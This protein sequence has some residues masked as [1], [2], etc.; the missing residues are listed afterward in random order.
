MYGRRRAGFLLSH[1]LELGAV[2][3]EELC[4]VL[5][6]VPVQ[7]LQV[8]VVDHASKH[9][10]NVIFVVIRVGQRRVQDYLTLAVQAIVVLAVLLVNRT[11]HVAVRALLP[12]SFASNC[13]QVTVTLAAVEN[14]LTHEL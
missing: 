11:L 9:L 2:V 7:L 12:V 10:R 4:L 6:S 3:D 1:D 13:D 14:V 5:P 8:F